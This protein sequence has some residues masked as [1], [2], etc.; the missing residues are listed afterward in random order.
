MSNEREYV[1]S[2][3][4]QERFKMETSDIIELPKNGRGLVIASQV[5]S[6]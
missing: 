6:G 4:L 3:L 5:Q 2:E 1:G